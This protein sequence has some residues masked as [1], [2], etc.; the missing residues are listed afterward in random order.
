M[1][2][3]DPDFRTK[4]NS[5]KLILKGNWLAVNHPRLLGV[6]RQFLEPGSGLAKAHFPQHCRRNSCHLAIHMQSAPHGSHW[7]LQLQLG[8]PGP[9]SQSFF[10]GGGIREQE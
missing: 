6:H 3:F 9:I 4:T 5:S 2:P 10:F 1:P 7:R 8:D